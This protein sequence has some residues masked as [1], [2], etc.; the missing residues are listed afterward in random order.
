MKPMSYWWWCAKIKIQ[1]PQE[2]SKEN[3]QV[4]N[5]ET[6]ETAAFKRLFDNDTDFNDDVKSL[7]QMKSI[8]SVTDFL[9]SIKT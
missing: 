5:D 6:C 1:D 8:G 3:E 9:T 7:F 4:I 2:H